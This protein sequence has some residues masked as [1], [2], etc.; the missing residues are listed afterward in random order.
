LTFTWIGLTIAVITAELDATKL[1]LAAKDAVIEC[2]PASRLDVVYTA[3]PFV[4]AA[5]PRTVLPS[6]KVTFPVAD[7]GVTAAVK[8]TESPK[9]TAAVADEVRAIDMVAGLTD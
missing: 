1:P 5:L 9:F 7:A 4:I 8:V 2:D 6:E 3:W